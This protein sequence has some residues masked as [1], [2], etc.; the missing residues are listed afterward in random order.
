VLVT[1]LP[2]AVAGRSAWV[3]TVALFAQAASS[4][5]ARWAVGRA[6]DRRGHARL[7]VPGV[8]LTAA[9]LLA[10]AVTASPVLVI[11]GAAVFGAGFGLLQNASLVLMYSRVPADGH[12]AVSA[13][14]N[15]AYDAGMGVGAIGMGL[16]AGAI[17]YPAVFA[18][19][20]LLTLI[21]LLPARRERAGRR[22]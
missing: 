9:G 18:L 13:I 16:V 10:L 5:V 4:T 2:L 1:F 21:A 15:A 14:W 3:A 11:G 8:V 17:G 12:T 19:T 7:L 6:G 22:A 20:G